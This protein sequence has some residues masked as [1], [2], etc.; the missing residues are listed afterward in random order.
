ME[1]VTINLDKVMH[2]IFR[3]KTRKAGMHLH[4]CLMEAVREARKATGRYIHTGKKI[5]GRHHGSW[6]GAIGYMILLDHIGDCY[7]PIESQLS[8]SN[9]YLRALEYF[10]NLG[11]R[12]RNALYALRCS[13][14]HEFSLSNIPKCRR[15]SLKGRFQH[16]FVVCVGGRFV[17]RLPKRCW[18][19]NHDHISDECKTWVDLE[20]FGDMVEEVVASLKELEKHKKLE[21]TLNGGKKEL[22]QRYT[23]WTGWHGKPPAPLFPC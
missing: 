14:A 17:V 9:G 4:S 20:G 23:F 22:F 8:R 21:A 1:T 3:R 13:F 12:D 16:R 10:T 5:P 11:E 18:D 19:G 7:K 6:L 15:E 2:Y